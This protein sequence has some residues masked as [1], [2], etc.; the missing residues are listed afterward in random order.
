[1]AAGWLFP[2]RSLPIYS[3]SQEW[4]SSTLFFG[5]FAYFYLKK[6]ID[7]DT[8]IFG[9][10]PH[11]AAIVAIIPLFG[12]VQIVCGTHP[13]PIGVGFFAC[14]FLAFFFA[15]QLGIDLSLDA[16]KD[17]NPAGFINGFS[18][19]LKWIL[20]SG[21]LSTCIVFMQLFNWDIYL[22]PLVRSPSLMEFRPSANLSQPNLMTLQLVFSIVAAGWLYA[23]GKLPSKAL[24]ALVIAMAIAIVFANTRAYL[25][26]LGAVALGALLYQG[27]KRRTL[28]LWPLVILPSIYLLLAPFHHVLMDIFGYGGRMA[29]NID[30]NS[31]ARVKIWLASIDI[32]NTHPWM[33]VGLGA[34]SIGF[35]E[36]A[37]GPLG[38][39]GAT[40]N[41]HNLTL[42]LMAECGF[43][44]GLVFSLGVAYW[45]FKRLFTTNQA[46]WKIASLSMVGAALAHSLVEFPLWFFSFLIPVAFFSGLVSTDAFLCIKNSSKSLRISVFCGLVTLG[47]SGLIW[48]LVDFLDLQD[49]YENGITIGNSE[50]IKKIS[51]QDRFS[52]FQWHYDYGRFLTTE[53]DGKNSEEIM[54]LGRKS[55]QR[56]PFIRGLARYAY[57]SATTKHINEAEGSLKVLHQMYPK[58]FEVFLKQN[59]ALCAHDAALNEVHCTLED[60]AKSIQSADVLDPAA[61]AAW[62]ISHPKSDLGPETGRK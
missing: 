45:Y 12:I 46:S 21:F 22:F 48:S 15:S 10:I 11:I 36:A 47:F 56:F 38:S 9:K 59:N 23:E 26:M 30:I 39:V 27:P 37:K 34:Y 55:V 44:I 3:F 61:A 8:H 14:G 2:L 19:I 62:T 28:L 29:F 4:L 43:I 24:T 57:V 31:D 50:A 5:I 6:I 35:F 1:M 18:I 25:L 20:W 53:L 13:Q 54:S 52:L 33:G 41:A 49:N 40:G 17:G 16:K 58:A 32:I 51:N 42:Q 7:K 60:L